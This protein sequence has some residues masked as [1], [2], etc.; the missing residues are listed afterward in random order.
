MFLSPAAAATLYHLSAKE[1][2]VPDSHFRTWPP[3]STVFAGSAVLDASVRAADGFRRTAAS[4]KSAARIQLSVGGGAVNSAAAFAKASCVE[5]VLCPIV[6]QD[7]EGEL[8]VSRLLKRFAHVVPI[9][10]ASET[11]KSVIKVDPASGKS[12]T[13]TTRSTIDAAATLAALRPVLS[14]A[15]RLVVASMQAEDAGLLEQLRNVFD[16]EMCLLASAS[17]CR[18][19]ELSL[20]LFS[21]MQLVSMN[22]EELEEVSKV[23]RGE[24]TGGM[25]ALRT[26]GVK[27]LI[28]TAD[29]RGIWGLLDEQWGHALA[30]EVPTGGENSSGCGDRAIGTLIAARDQGHDLSWALKMAAAAGAIHA[31]RLSCGPGW[32]ALEEFAASTPTFAFQPPSRPLVRRSILISGAASVVLAAVLRMATI[33]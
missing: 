1:H 4:E 10:T 27:G 13:D 28:A 25:D 19:G 11:R 14:D 21:R 33:G 29:R 17:Q 5:P 3:H 23:R 2:P 8:V 16:G 32:P 9:R 31:G 12:H 30:F 7:C 15:R 22:A 6:G 24:V 18:Q 26:A 20:S